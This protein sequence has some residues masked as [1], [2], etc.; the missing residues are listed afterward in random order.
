M[1]NNNTKEWNDFKVDVDLENDWLVQLNSLPNTKL[2]N[3]CSGHDIEGMTALG[4]DQ[5]P[6]VVFKLFIHDEIDYRLC[7]NSLE[8]GKIINEL[9][10][11]WAEVEW[12]LGDGIAAQDFSRSKYY[13][14]FVGTLE[15]PNNMIIN[16]EGT[17][18]SGKV[19]EINLRVKSKINF[20]ESNKIMIAYWWENL[21]NT[22][23]KNLGIA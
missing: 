2:I 22:L 14:N 10:D 18:I 3:I 9:K 6:S 12:L 23:K 1:K 21:I 20:Q 4:G 11:T 8:I 19:C 5:Y 17:I 15:L 7:R 13:R 16:G